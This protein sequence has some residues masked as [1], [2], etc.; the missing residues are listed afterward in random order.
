MTTT[1]VLLEE[2]EV[3]LIADDVA[4]FDQIAA[5]SQIGPFTLERQPT[6]QL[7]TTYLD[8]VD[9]IITRH[10]L[11]L[12]LRRIGDDGWEVSTK[13][14]GQVTGAIHARPERTVVLPSA[15]TFPFVP[16]AELAE[17][18]PAVAIEQTL[19]PILISEV[20]RQRF[21]I[22][23]STEPEGEALAEMVLDTAGY[24]DP[25][26]PERSLATFYEVEVELEAGT[27]DELKR[28]SR[29]LQ[30]HFSLR[31]SGENKLHRGLAL[32]YGPGVWKGSL[33]ES[34]AVQCLTR[35]I[36]PNLPGDIRTRGRLR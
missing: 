27:Q 14:Q 3:K 2:V 19:T 25:K 1:G 36:S 17:G 13:G 24:R 9:F 29:F 5:L 22:R 28:I 15:P 16:P 7:Q 20:E 11:A 33:R 4:V 6:L 8:T 30:D 34:K 26:A 32:L 12:R 23:R 21:A 31:P 35:H 10:A 18:L